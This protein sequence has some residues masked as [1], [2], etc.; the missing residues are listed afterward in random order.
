MSKKTFELTETKAI[1]V[2]AIEI[3]GQRSVSLRQMYKT[4][5]D[6]NW[7]HGKQGITLPLEEAARIAKMITKFATSDETTFKEIEVGKKNDD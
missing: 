6:P 5:N 7:K 2:E 3:K 4:R 1:Q